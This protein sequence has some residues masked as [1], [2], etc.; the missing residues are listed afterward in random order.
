LAFKSAAFLL[1][2]VVDQLFLTRSGQF[3]KRNWQNKRQVG[4]IDE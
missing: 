1:S 2:R 4:K 3:I